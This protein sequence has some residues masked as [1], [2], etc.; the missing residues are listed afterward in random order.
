M[1][2]KLNVWKRDPVAF[3]CDVLVNPE[4]H[5]PFEL[6]DAQ[7]GFLR[8]AF[9]PVN[10]RLPHPE[11]IF[12]CPKK[13][14]KSCLASWCA[15]YVAVV[16]GGP[17]AEVYCLS[18][19][20]EQSVGRVFESARRIIEASPL[21]RHSAKITA[22]RIEFRSTGSFIQAVASDYAS[23]A[24][25]NPSLCIFDELWGYVSERSRRLWDEA[26]P[27]PVRAVSA[28]LTVSYSGFS[29]ESD[30]LEGL[31]MRGIAGGEVAPD[32]Y[33]SDGMLCYWTH[34][35]RA[36]WQSERW[37]NEMRKALRPNQFARMI[38]N[39]WVRG[40]GDFLQEAWIEAC[41]NPELRPSLGDSNLAVFVGIDA[42]TKHDWCAVVATTYDDEAQKVRLVR[43]YVWKPTPDKPLDFVNTIERAVLELQERFWLTGVYYD[44]W[45]LSA[46]AQRLTDAGVRME[47]FPQTLG[48]L[49]AMGE[50]LL[51]LFKDRNIEIY[52]DGDLAQSLR[53]AVGVESA[54]GFKIGKAAAARKIDLVVALAMSALAAVRH[55]RAGW[56]VLQYTRQRAEMAARGETP[57][58]DTSLA[59][60]YWKVRN[61]LERMSENSLCP[62][63]KKPLGPT[64]TL[65]SD[66]KYYHPECVRGW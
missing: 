45:Q 41:T 2:A 59:D 3:I 65:N 10:G 7:V 57:V 34:E 37:K 14:G 55:E 23:F 8:R 49:T 16:I 28:R 30:L 52:A 39:K 6:Y 20:Y 15:I 66:G 26:V 42:S 5:K 25:S 33:Q 21:L 54:R 13:S 32:L 64:K 11:L 9:I 44:P 62:K 48:N 63:C 50:N 24:G 4:N 27:S 51:A 36:P 46:V 19:D 12:S 38:G 1:K 60:E 56:G 35:C 29:D 40:E 22:G 61:E 18:N 43:H 47:E 17:L 58:E 31:Y 53:N